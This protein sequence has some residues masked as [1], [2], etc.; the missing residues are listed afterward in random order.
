MLIKQFTGTTIDEILPQ[1]RAELGE[2]AL[3]LA[4]R[5]VTRGG[6]GGFFGREVLEVTAAEGGTREEIAEANA[7]AAARPGEEHTGGDHEPF[8]R[9]LQG[10]LA[11]A[12]EA[13]EGLDRVAGDGVMG[14]GA[15]G[16]PAASPAGAYLR[17]METSAPA[18]R[19]FGPGDT[20]RT[21]AI[22][23][24]ARQAMRQAHAQSSATG[25]AMTMAAANMAAADAARRSRVQ[26]PPWA[27]SAP[28]A[29]EDVA[30]A[31]PGAADQPAP[32]TPPPA[33][34]RATGVDRVAPMT[35]ISPAAASPGVARPAWAPLDRVAAP[36][37]AAAEPAHVPAAVMAVPAPAAEE[38][39]P[40]GIAPAPEVVIPAVGPPAS[41]PA[42]P[43]APAASS[44]Q[45]LVLLTSPSA[46]QGENDPVLLAA[47]AELVEAGVHERYL[48]PMLDAFR[49]AALPFADDGA[50]MRAMLRQWIAAR[51][52]VARDW[53]ARAA[54][55]TIVLV[56]QSGVGKTTTA[57]KLAG[58]MSA[59]GM[60]V[61]LVAAGQGSHQALEAHARMLGVE[62]IL[63][64]DAESLL[65]A[66]KA[67]SDRDLVVVDTTG[68][69]HQDLDGIEDLAAL[70]GPARPD[71]VHLVLPVTS[72]LA[73]LGDVTRRFRIAGVNRVSVT[74]LDE[75]RFHG[76]LVN[77]PLRVG[78]PLGFVTDGSSVPGALR[79]AD[80]LLI[81]EMLLP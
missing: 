35:P 64:E 44:L 77:F 15:G 56:G 11:A 24:A 50:D 21:Q 34:R 59:A 43:S 67:L 75:T 31:I 79:P 45:P 19:P 69:S 58:R 36:A 74:K 76:N 70:V 7:H 60:R 48:D 25:G 14:P 57:C 13:E 49:R 5:R 6:L 30:H 27:T 29:R 3:I 26:P 39:E 42:V 71:E 32:T 55:H 53:K 17:G 23:E 54:G 63:A 72:S 80:A 40:A 78:K 52:P 68:R 41:P 8:S 37:P 20:E 46:S 28:L 81:A 33:A 47:R 10:R 16:A 73:D 22:I 18:T 61:A 38:S 2:D 62:A 12:L 51:L 4:T 1:I 9:H 66:R 65:Q